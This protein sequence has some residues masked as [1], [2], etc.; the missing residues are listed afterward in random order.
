MLS[1]PG[2]GAIDTNYRKN[3]K[4]DQ[5]EAIN[6]CSVETPGREFNGKRVLSFS[7]KT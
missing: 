7:M 6:F 2:G 4:F 3:A 1:D 5:V